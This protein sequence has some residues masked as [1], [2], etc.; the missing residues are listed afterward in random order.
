MRK[1]CNRPRRNRVQVTDLVSRMR[2]V[3]PKPSRARARGRV[4]L[5]WRRRWLVRGTGMCSVNSCKKLL[6][7]LL[8][9]VLYTY[10]GV[11]SPCLWVCACEI[12][13]ETTEYLPPPP[14]G[15]TELNLTDL[16]K[17]RSRSASSAKAALAMCPFARRANEW[18]RGAR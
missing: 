18:L 7:N 11:K 4:A 5:G 9:F 8:R 16:A 10:Q 12:C 13:C 1:I 14:T 17:A 6:E 15:S 2:N 3:E